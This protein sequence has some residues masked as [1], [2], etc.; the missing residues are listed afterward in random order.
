VGEPGVVLP[1]HRWL[2]EELGAGLA[3][4][5]ES[6]GADRPR[7]A[8]SEASSEP[9]N[10]DTESSVYDLNL[11]G[12][13]ALA[14]ST[15]A[16]GSKEIATRVLTALG[17]EAP[18]DQLCLETFREVIGQGVSL[19]AQSL[20]SRLKK[21]AAFVAN[22]SKPP[23]ID[24]GIASALTI[25]FGSEPPVLLYIRLSASLLE[26]LA[27][28]SAEKA[29]V[30]TANP[31]IPDPENL[32]TLED[33]EMVLTVCLGNARLTLADAMILG[34]GSTVQLDSKLDDLVAIKVD[35]KV[36]ARGEVVDVDG[37]YAIRITHL[38]D[39]RSAPVSE[40]PSGIPAQLQS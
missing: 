21:E 19:L 23:A 27:A 37:S 17:M 36:V 39:F 22:P 24:A 11:T 25:T 12:A 15:S 8:V 33:L 3:T 28:P 16:A 32:G 20:G 29:Q 18:A 30:P 9:G 31:D 34:P 13:P 4:A 2:L 26:L 7:C 6:M 35:G 10:D 14:I 38:A 40:R 5:V 1:E